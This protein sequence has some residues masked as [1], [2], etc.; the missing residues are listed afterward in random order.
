MSK[1]L[2]H[3]ELI[4]FQIRTLAN[5]NEK[6]K[7]ENFPTQF[8]KSGSSGNIVGQGRTNRCNKASPFQ[9][10]MPAAQPFACKAKLYADLRAVTLKYDTSM[11]LK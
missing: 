5:T 2:F 4:N 11:L 10:C 8:R 6:C 7:R 1:T 3:H 9:F